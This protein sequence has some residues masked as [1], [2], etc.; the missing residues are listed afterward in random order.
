M[1]KCLGLR[2]RDYF[3]EVT[4]KAI[5]V[6]YSNK[7]ACF[8]KAFGNYNKLLLH[9]WLFS[10]VNSKNAVLVKVDYMGVGFTQVFSLPKFQSLVP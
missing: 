4:K 8:S 9:M 3:T 2:K 7:S 6:H 5:T 10:H 1:N